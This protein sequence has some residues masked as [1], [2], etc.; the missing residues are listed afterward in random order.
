MMNVRK[1]WDG[2]TLHSG[3]GPS[4]RAPGQPEPAA[5]D[6]TN[7][8]GD[9]GDRGERGGDPDP[10]LI[11]ERYRVVSRLGAGGYG[12]VY[13][14]VDERIDKPVAVKVL[15]RQAAGSASAVQRFR[16]EALAAGRLAHPGIVAVSD[17]ET[18]PDGRPYIVMELIDGDTLA[19]ELQA[20]GSLPVAEAVRITIDICAALDRVHKLGIVHRDLTPA[21]IML[22]AA[23]DGEPRAVKV[24]DFG[25]AKLLERTGDESL[26]QNG[27]LIGTPAYMSPEQ[28]R[29]GSPIDH[30]TDLY[31]GGVILYAMLAG[32]LPFS[33]GHVVDALVAKL[34]DDPRPLRELVP[35]LPRGLEDIVGKA[36]ARDP[37]QRFASAAELAAALQPYRSASPATE[38]PAPRSSGRRWLMLLVGAALAAGALAALRPKRAP[39]PTPAAAAPLPAPVPAPAPEAPKVE[40]APAPTTPAPPPPEEKPAKPARVH[41]APSGGHADVSDLPDAPVRR[42]RVRP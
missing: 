31:S 26:T 6:R 2:E 33:R 8:R 22:C 37:G 13:R 20:R 9:T 28:A 34:V 41:H 29:A 15:S 1:D 36:M 38:A 39:A 32:T 24:L 40:L 27:Q 18:L 12:I 21:N 42:V 4:E 3:G 16:N 25:I 11:A 17:F 19:H 7:E 35:N 10:T 23:H 5:V 30:R 14:A